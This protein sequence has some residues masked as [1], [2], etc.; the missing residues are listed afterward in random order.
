MLL[1]TLI[2]VLFT[3]PPILAAVVFHE[4]AHGWVARA[5]GDLTA[6]KLGRLSPNPIAHVDPVGTI[7]VPGLL[8]LTSAGFFFGWAKPVPVDPRN[9]TKPRRDMAIVAVAGPLANLGMLVTWTVF[10]LAISPIDSLPPGI[11]KPL[12]HMCS[13]GIIINGVLMMLNLLPIPP[14]DGSRIVAAALPSGFLFYYQHI[15]RFG[16]II[17]LLLMFSGVLDGILAPLEWVFV[18]LGI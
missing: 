3:V 18:K 7:L 17:V 10:L 6:A 2:K 16:L 5:L 1:D 14:L 13:V 8:L 15:E 11:A 12:I 9:F 4:L